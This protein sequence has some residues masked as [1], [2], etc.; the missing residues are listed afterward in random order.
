MSKN[1]GTTLPP[2]QSATAPDLAVP[3]AFISLRDYFAGRGAP[4][5]PYVT[6]EELWSYFRNNAKDTLEALRA[7][8]AFGV[9]RDFRYADT[10]M[11]EREKHKDS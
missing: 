6:D 10:M 4:S 5:L 11:A 7:Y 9:T 8:D 1:D 2:E 3:H